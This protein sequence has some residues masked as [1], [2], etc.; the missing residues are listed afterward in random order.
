MLREIF[1][2]HAQV[3][4]E[5][6]TRLLPDL[7]R[8]AELAEACLAAGNKLLVFGNGGSAA[9]AQHFAAELVG[10]F[11]R[12]RR[13]LPAVALTVDTSLLT[14]VANDHGFEQIFARQVE[15]LGGPGDLLVAL[16]T[17]GNSANVLSAVDKGREMGCRAI[18]FTGEGGGRLA[19]RVDVLIA[20]P[21]RTVARIQEIH[22]LCLHALA[23]WLERR[24]CPEE[25]QGRRE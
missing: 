24:L 5:A 10:R 1:D 18:G 17:S 22:E 25:D 4:E 3:F 7:E 15:A 9:D 12:D 6:R 11:E 23:A 21:S 20:A 13:P 8:A 2:E 19:D 16:S 14:A